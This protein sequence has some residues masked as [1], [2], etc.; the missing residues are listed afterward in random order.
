M[1]ESN[2]LPASPGA[3]KF[4]SDTIFR[5]APFALFIVFLATQPYLERV[6]DSRWVV[7]SRGLAVAAVLACLWRHYGELHRERPQAAASDWFLALV[8]GVGVLGELGLDGTIRPVPGVLVL[9]DALSA[10]IR[11]ILA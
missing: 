3:G 4:D 8:A 2:F 10:L 11:R 5:V 1:S 9:A 7:V 6:F